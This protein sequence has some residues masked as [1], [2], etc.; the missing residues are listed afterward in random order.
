MKKIILI[1]CGGH[2]KSVVDAIEASG[3]Y[4]IIGFTDTAEKADFCYRGYQ[5]LG[6]DTRLPTLFEKGVCEA[7]VCIGYMGRN[8][9]RNQL[10]C[11]LKN[12]GFSLAAVVD[13]SAI[14][15]KDVKIGEGTFVGKRAVINSAAV[16]GKMAI[17][18]TG[19]VIEHDSVVGDF[20][21][22]ACGAVLC[23][24]MT[25]GANS[26]VGANAVIVQGVSLPEDTFVKAG[27]L[28]KGS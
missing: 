10:Y 14:I 2:A 25:L 26:M 28:R 15:A 11:T 12:I 5:V 22:V 6:D 27:A 18:N 19:A 17:I 24:G 21:H 16:V 8:R 7:F 3:A 13:P 23:G 1:G 9:L 4:E 20:C